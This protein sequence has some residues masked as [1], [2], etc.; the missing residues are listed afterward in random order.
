MMRSPNHVQTFDP[1]SLMYIVCGGSQNW[2]ART[3]QNP[4]RV[5]A[6]LESSLPGF[7]DS[8]VHTD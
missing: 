6:H 1:S 4:N 8:E 2:P 7:A 5:L 3:H